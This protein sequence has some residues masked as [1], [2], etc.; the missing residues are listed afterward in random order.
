MYFHWAGGNDYLDSNNIDFNTSVNNIINHINLLRLA[1]A[2]NIVVMGQPD[3]SASSESRRRFGGT[4]NP[5]DAEALRKSKAHNEAL[6]NRLAEANYPVLYVDIFNIFNDVRNHYKKFGFAA[7][8]D[9][10]HTDGIHPSARSH[11]ILAQI[12]A[13]NHLSPIKTV[14]QMYSSTSEV[15]KNINQGL[16]QQSQIYLDSGSKTEAFMFGQIGAQKTAQIKDNR[17]KSVPSNVTVGVKH[18][19]DARVSVGLAFSQHQQKVKTINSVS[20]FR[21]VG[22]A[23]SAFLG[24]QNRLVFVKTILQ[25]GRENFSKITREFKLSEAT[26]TMQGKTSATYAS[27][28]V[29]AGLNFNTKMV[30]VSPY[31]ELQN[32][33]TRIAPYT[34]SEVNG[35]LTSLNLDIHRQKANLA[36]GGI[37]AKIVYQFNFGMANYIVSVDFA[38]FF[39]LDPHAT[40]IDYNPSTAAKTRASFDIYPNEAFT[41]F[42]ISVAYVPIKKDSMNFSLGFSRAKGT[43]GTNRNYATISANLP[44]G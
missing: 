36:L 38:N 41:R 35:E 18:I 43:K 24:Y 29:Q 44:I 4:P 42:D 27:S 25:Y 30:L 26:V 16:L 7:A 6:I 8:T 28:T 40:S 21:N 37:G 17:V 1:G 33:Q 34:E 5:T 31:I 11:E 19:A 15:I 39:T 9:T 32:S 20:S 14:S 22:Q 2:K 3:Y 23:Y 12:L 13:F 10:L